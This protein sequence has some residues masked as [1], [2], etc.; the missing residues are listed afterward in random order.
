M[1]Q[2]KLAARKN[3]NPTRG[4]S[5]IGNARQA[6]HLGSVITPGERRFLITSC[7]TA[8]ILTKKNGS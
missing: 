3:D 6:L 4:I 1:A 8:T 5:H 7:T 2:L